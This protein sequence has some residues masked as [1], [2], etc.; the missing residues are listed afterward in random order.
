MFFS[1]L[2][3]TYLFFFNPPQQDTIIWRSMCHSFVFYLSW[4]VCVLSKEKKPDH[5]YVLNIVNVLIL[6]SKNK[7]IQ[8]TTT[9]KTENCFC[10]AWK[11]PLRYW[12]KSVCSTCKWRKSGRLVNLLQLLF[13]SS[14]KKKTTLWLLLLL[15][16]MASDLN[17]DLTPMCWLIQRGR[18][19]TTSILLSEF[20]FFS[21]FSLKC[22][23]I[24]FCDI[25]SNMLNLSFQLNIWLHL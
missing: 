9:K 17:S 6:L 24:F 19:C 7:T 18:T 11:L 3:F 1:L 25:W 22:F 2:K 8:K 10:E 14:L 13:V 23:D 16:I 5:F 21:H 4:A 20:S 15:H 12:E